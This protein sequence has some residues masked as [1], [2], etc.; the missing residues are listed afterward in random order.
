MASALVDCVILVYLY[1]DEDKSTTS[2]ATRGPKK[3]KATKSE[4]E[5]SQQRVEQSGSSGS[6]EQNKARFK[7]EIQRLS[8]LR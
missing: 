5:A 2:R 7:I 1:W 3:T 8:T 6:V 4:T